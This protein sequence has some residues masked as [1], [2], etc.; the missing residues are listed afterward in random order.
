MSAAT[1][2]HMQSESTCYTQVHSGKMNEIV[3]GEGARHSGTSTPVPENTNRAPLIPEAGDV[4]VP[5]KSQAPRSPT[6]H[7]EKSI[8]HDVN[9]AHVKKDEI[10]R[11][12]SP[13][14]GTQG[15]SASSQPPNWQQED[16]IL[17]AA[18]HGQAQGTVQRDVEQVKHEQSVDMADGEMR[19]P[20]GLAKSGPPA[21]DG[22]AH[23][24]K[25]ADL[26]AGKPSADGEGS[27]GLPYDTN[28]K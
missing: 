8:G 24:R 11:D 21:V 4:A 27:A 6:G 2:K 9:S 26:L 3:D 20:T 22:A 15:A 25:Q 28:S 19:G 14:M 1:V 16:K 5:S 13:G 10:P 12:G 17:D 23:D 7:G 18:S